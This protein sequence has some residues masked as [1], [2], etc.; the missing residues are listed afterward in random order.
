LKKIKKL[1]NLQLIELTDITL[2]FICFDFK[3]IYF[4]GVGTKIAD[5]KEKSHCCAMLK[6]NISDNEEVIIGELSITMGYRQE[7]H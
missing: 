5:I 6:C 7:L 4:G 1:D 3:E 2:S